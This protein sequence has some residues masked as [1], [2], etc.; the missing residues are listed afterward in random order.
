VLLGGGGA[1]A[2]AA[3]PAG[4]AQLLLLALLCC[5]IASCGIGWLAPPHPSHIHSQQ[6][7]PN[8]PALTPS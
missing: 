1:A 6:L 2:A 4:P 5:C 8:T 3:Q 7:H